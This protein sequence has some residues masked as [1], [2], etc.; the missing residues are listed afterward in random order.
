MVVAGVRRMLR[1]R[2]AHGEPSGPPPVPPRTLTASD[3]RCSERRE[4]SPSLTSPA[5]DNVH[6]VHR[7][8]SRWSFTASLPCRPRGSR[9]NHHPCAT[10]SITVRT[11]GPRP[12]RPGRSE[13][14]ATAHPP[15][16]SPFSDQLRLP[17][18]VAAPPVNTLRPHRHRDRM[19]TGT[20]ESHLLVAAVLTF[21]SNGGISRT[22]ESKSG[23]QDKG[24]SPFN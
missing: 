15:S 14:S 4:L 7:P 23:G 1:A 21:A 22:R 10:R 20:G 16:R 9:P 11:V 24:G 13:G 18:H 12:S 19:F 6:V 2:R 8:H 17:L 3:G 5:T